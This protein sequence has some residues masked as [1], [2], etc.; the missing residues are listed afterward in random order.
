M[1]TCMYKIICI[2]NRKLCQGDFGEQ[3]Q[4]IISAKPDKIIV[5]EK[6]LTEND[7]SILLERIVRMCENSGIEVT[8]HSFVNTAKMLGVRSI[9]VPLDRL[10]KMSE[11]EKQFFHQIG[12]SCHSVEDAQ[13]ALALGADYIIAGHIFETD[14]KKGLAGRGLD[15]LHEVCTS[16]SLPVYAIGGINADNIRDIVRAGAEGAC[17][18]SSFMQCQDPAEYLTSLKNIEL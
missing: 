3:M 4:K 12:A 15:F 2:T 10:R 5:R 18:M 6:D 16:V 1:I 17:L 11:D 14:C 7:Y 9:H 13:E 8:A